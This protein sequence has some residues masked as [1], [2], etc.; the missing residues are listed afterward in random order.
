MKMNK[1]IHDPDEM[2]RSTQNAQSF[3]RE[4]EIE[5]LIHE[6]K[7][8]LAI[9]ET[10]LRT[11]MERRDKYGSLS[12]GQE[13]TLTRALRN[14][15]K[16]R[17]MLNNLLEIGRSE[18]GCFICCL[19]HPAQSAYQSLRDSL[20]TV[21]GSIFEQFRNYENENE[22][23][24]FLSK[25]GIFLDI[26]PGVVQAEMFQDEIK[27][28]QI[29]GNLI[30]NGLHHRR[31]RLEVKMMLEDDYLVTEVTDDGPGIDPDHHELIFKRYAQVNECSIVPRKGH[32]LGLAGALILA[33]CLGG[34]I[35]VKSQK[36][37][38]ATFRLTLPLRLEAAQGQS[39]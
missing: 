20:E 7:D 3:F 23:L 24:T 35:A 6:L 19:F 34:D 8:P 30:K 37:R 31:N 14:S 13:K 36:G 33:R 5:F 27:F 16:A 32:G 17:E 28:R 10:G 39:R 9:I 18:A 38:G 11:L 4:I 26:A 2:H 22:A 21:A 1:Q 12:S 29:V 25:S 15:K